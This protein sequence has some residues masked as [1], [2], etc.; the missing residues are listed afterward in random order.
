MKIIPLKELP[1]EFF[2]GFGNEEAAGVRRIVEDV[3]RYGDWAV[4]H[5]T[6]LFDGVEPAVF[7]VPAEIIARAETA[8]DPGLR[9]ALALSVRNIRTFAEA[10]KAESRDFELETS[11]GV[12]CGQRVVPIHRVGIYVPAGRF[13]LVSS[14]LMGAIPALVAGVREIAV[15]S[16][17]TS[18]GTVHPVILG[19]AG[20]L[21]LGEIYAVGGAQAVAALAFGTESIPRVDK[22]VGPGNR[23]VTAAKRE[24][25]GTVGIDLMAGPSEV[26]I[27]ADRS[28]EASIAAADLLA[29]AEHDPDAS[30][31][32]LT[33]SRELA[34]AVLKEVGRRLSALPDPAVAMQSL[35][36]RSWII[37]L[38]DLKEAVEIAN[39]RAPEHLELQGSQAIALADRFLCY[40]ALF[41]GAEAGE[42]FGDYT[43]GT[44]HTLPTGTAARFASGLNVRDFLKFQ[45][46][47]RLEEQGIDSLVPA[48][49]RLAE[50]EGLAAHAAAAAVR[51][52]KQPGSF[53]NQSGRRYSKKP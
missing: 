28:A 25:F 51:L 27:V 12:F 10:Q 29:Q 39:R 15:C 48:T 8:L 20:L 4:R 16:P 30:A 13:P 1:R 33:D 23:F 52:K 2:T 35:D 38:N 44:N 21:G 24:V 9:E 32:L 46:T 36:R 6:R 50:G 26:L 41:I 5:F 37:I 53:A 49:R 34:E 40:G 31:I 7:H 42:V 11:P 47:L 22:I 3:R 43:A 14:F 19:A 45:T 18:N 17:P